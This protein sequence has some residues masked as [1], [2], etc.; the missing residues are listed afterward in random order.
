M[1]H[2]NEYFA[3][4]LNNN[5][6]NNNNNNT[7][8]YNALKINTLELGMYKSLLV[9]VFHCNISI[10]YHPAATNGHR[11]TVTR[12]SLNCYKQTPPISVNA[13]RSGG[14]LFTTPNGRAIDNKR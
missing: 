4:S 1:L 2:V 9:H 7:Q 14:S 3:K 11:N 8:T 10:A 12:V 6:S 13:P 5:N